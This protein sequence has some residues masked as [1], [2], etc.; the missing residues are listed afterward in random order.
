MENYRTFIAIELPAD[1]RRQ[2]KAYVDQL[3]AAFPGVRAS[4]SRED[5][6]HLT[7]KFLG[8]VPVSRIDALSQACAQAAVKIDPFDLAISDCGTFPPHGKPK[9]LWIGVRYAGVA[10]ASSSHPPISD[11]QD[12]LHSLH[13]AIENGCAAAGFARESRPYHPHLTIARIREAKDARAL[14]EYHQ[15]CGFPT[16]TFAVSEV[17]VFRSELSS[18]GSQHTYLSHHRLA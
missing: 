4:W 2:L 8:D 10:P 12:P 7:L 9:V 6:L 16:Q 14:A 1:I 3:R 18:Q 13:T 11:A 17:V 15:Q 5:N